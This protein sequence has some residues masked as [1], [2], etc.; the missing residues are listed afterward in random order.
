MTKTEEYRSILHSLSDWEPFLRSHSGLPGPRANLELLQVV[1]DE[2]DGKT[3]ERFLAFGPD[4]A[5]ENTPGVF[6]AACGT[7]AL[8]RL[9]E[10]GNMDVLPQ[11]RALAN[12]HR[13]RVRESVA[14]ALQR[15]GDTDLQKLIAVARDWASG[16]LLEQRAAIAAI[17]EPRLLND[18]GAV[19]ATLDLLDHVTNSI[20]DASQ[21]KTEDFR[22][23]RKALAYCWSVA[24]AAFPEEGKPRFESWSITTDPDVRFIL[25]ENLKK[26]RLIRMDPAWVNQFNQKL[27]F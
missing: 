11:L 10:E 20:R 14:M 2:A 24:V 9:L 13:W 8:G 1:A 7:V 26:N 3:I 15:L 18:P 25:R 16:S 22:V 27:G 4:Q 5:P 17:C 23:L 6:L 19:R 21:R 12:D